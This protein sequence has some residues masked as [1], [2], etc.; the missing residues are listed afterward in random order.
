MSAPVV[1]RAEGS[2]PGRAGPR[3]ALGLPL[4]QCQ[5]QR[6]GGSRCQ[7]RCLSPGAEGEAGRAGT[8]WISVI[9]PP[10]ALLPLLAPGCLAARGGVLCSAGPPGAVTV[11]SSTR[12]LLQQAAREPGFPRAWSSSS[13]D[14]GSWL[15]PDSLLGRSCP[16]HGAQETPV[17]AP[18]LP[19]QT[20]QGCGE[21]H[22]FIIPLPRAGQVKSSSSCQGCTQPA[23]H[24]SRCSV[25]TQHHCQTPATARHSRRP[26]A[27]PSERLWTLP[28]V[29]QRPSAPSS[30]VLQTSL[31]H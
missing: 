12:L 27:T 15:P 24:P 22:E 1:R 19:T 14:G 6:P 17:G 16:P 7:D 20:P 23:Q 21:Q 9:G 11:G 29:P 25:P 4:H 3:P 18:A 28:P 30:Q 31:S 5:A 2:R 13:A 26:H 8:L 10:P